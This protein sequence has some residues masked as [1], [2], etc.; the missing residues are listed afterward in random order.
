MSNP[1][2][3]LLDKLGAFLSK[4]EG[5]E[6]AAPEAPAVPEPRASGQVLARLDQFSEVMEVLAQLTERL[7]ERMALLQTACTEA[8][9]LPPRE[10]TLHPRLALQKPAIVDLLRTNPI[11]ARLTAP[12]VLRFYEATDDLGRMQAALG[13][14]RLESVNLEAMRG[15]YMFL[16]KVQLYFKDHPQLAALFKTRAQPAAPVA[17]VP[18]AVE[19]RPFPGATG[20]LAPSPHPAYAR[21]AGQTGPDRLSLGGRAQGTGSLERPGPSPL[22][23]AKAL[24]EK[25][26]LRMLILRA[27]V[28]PMPTLQRKSQALLPP[29]AQESARAL[30]AALELAPEYRERAREGLRC[31]QEARALLERRT[32]PAR[33]RA[34]CTEL[35]ALPRRLAGHPLLER[36]FAA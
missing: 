21:L 1:A 22:Q 13:T 3:S 8:R 29:P 5:A 19:P 7:K 27:A 2:P 30:A 31:Y 11:A 25:L 10:V 33:L 36:L 35:S 17:S 15:R 24:L 34:L 9:L 14:G 16:S 6:V 23:A 18:V 20:G 4:L 32:E 28:E 26:E 12:A